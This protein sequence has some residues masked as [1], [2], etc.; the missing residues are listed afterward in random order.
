[1]SSLTS[2]GKLFLVRTA[3]SSEFHPIYPRSKHQRS[4][5]K[6][7]RGTDCDLG[8]VHEGLVERGESSRSSPRADQVADDART[9]WR[10]DS[11]YT[12]GP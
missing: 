12:H 1:M 7:V 4:S 3:P 8:R 11:W 5:L 2:S 10:V 6:A 9:G